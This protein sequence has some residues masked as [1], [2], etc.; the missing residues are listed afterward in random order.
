MSLARPKIS[1]ES[2]QVDLTSLFDFRYA[3]P[4][5]EACAV[6]AA[7]FEEADGKKAVLLA[8]SNDRLSSPK[9][10]SPRR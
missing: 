6:M 5:S 4:T 10:C 8:G 3:V 1:S 9:D 7:T 2:S